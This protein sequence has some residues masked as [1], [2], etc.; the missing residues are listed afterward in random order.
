MSLSVSTEKVSY[1]ISNFII[2]SDHIESVLCN[3]FL[4]ARLLS[5]IC[6][7]NLQCN[8]FRYTNFCSV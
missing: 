1:G 5:P 2:V 3:V 6:G 4:S 8:I 7:C